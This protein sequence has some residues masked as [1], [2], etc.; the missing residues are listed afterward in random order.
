MMREPVQPNGIGD[1]DMVEGLED[2]PE[3]RAAVSCHFFFGEVARN[4]IHPLV[5]P[6]VV[7]RHQCK[8]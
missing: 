4:L 1:S 2:R 6:A 3:E 8:N 5:H 7:I